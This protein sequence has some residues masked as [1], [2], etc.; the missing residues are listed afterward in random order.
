MRR[1]QHC[2]PLCG[3]RSVEDRI[4]STLAF[5]ER[6]KKRVAAAE[7]KIAN[8]GGRREAIHGALG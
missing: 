7:E 6:A 2:S 8:V 3:T 4:E 1:I 5:V